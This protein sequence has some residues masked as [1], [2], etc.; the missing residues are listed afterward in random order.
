M[1]V[2]SSHLPKLGRPTSSLHASRMKK[3]DVSAHLP[4]KNL[5]PS[6]S[7]VEG[8]NLNCGPNHLVPFAPNLVGVI[9]I[10]IPPF[11]ECVNST[12]L[13]SLWGWG[14]ISSQRGLGA[15]PALPSL[16]LKGECPI[17]EM[18]C[19]V[20]VSCMWLLKIRSKLQGAYT[21]GKG[22]VV[23]GWIC[24]NMGLTSVG[25]LQGPI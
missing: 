19:L 18:Q 12:D 20:Y 2:Y 23:N 7:E 15:L 17:F 1:R 16:V 10:F 9:I 22:N 6:I 4:K 8:L 14:T 25:I 13:L 11:I 5:C 3:N 21:L 24:V